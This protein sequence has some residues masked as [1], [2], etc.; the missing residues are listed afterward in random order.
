MTPWSDGVPGVTQFPIRTGSTFI[1][2]YRFT[3][4]GAYW[5]H[6]HIVSGRRVLLDRLA[7]L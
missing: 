7:L 5:Y 4:S 1:Y 3:Q 2:E 6:A